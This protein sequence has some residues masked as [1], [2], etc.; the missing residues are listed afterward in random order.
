MN[1][2]R[3]PV[4]DTIPA[5]HLSAGIPIPITR[6]KQSGKSAWIPQQQEDWKMKAIISVT[7]L[8]LGVLFIAD[9]VFAEPTRPN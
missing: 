2:T 7:A 6:K 4:C 8:V 1:T 9:S 5:M 3:R